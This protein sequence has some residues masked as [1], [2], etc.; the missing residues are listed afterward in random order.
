ME[1]AHDH[2]ATLLPKKKGSKAYPD[3]RQPTKK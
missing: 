3:H 1:E 2:L